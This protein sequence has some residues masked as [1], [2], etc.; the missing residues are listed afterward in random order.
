MNDA[1]I[2]RAIATPPER[3]LDVYATSVALGLRQER[4]A[5]AAVL[6][7]LGAHVIDVPAQRLN[8]ALIDEYLRI[9]QRGLL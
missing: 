5:A 3:P 9:K 1:A 7:R 8:T 6:E 2:D 4:R